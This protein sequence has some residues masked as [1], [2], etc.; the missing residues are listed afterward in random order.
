MVQK[1]VHEPLRLCRNPRIGLRLAPSPV[2][3]TSVVT[4][5]MSKRGHVALGDLRIPGQVVQ[6]GAR[7]GAF[8]HAARDRVGRVGIG[9]EWHL[10]PRHIE[11]LIRLYSTVRGLNR[12]IGHFN[13]SV[14]SLHPRLSIR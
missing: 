2:P 13:R 4:Y 6:E 3:T 8:E 9:E 5:L 1:K 12:P 10:S 7:A 11:I 14:R